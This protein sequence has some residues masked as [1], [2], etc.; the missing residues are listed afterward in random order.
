[1][2]KPLK[3]FGRDGESQKELFGKGCDVSSSSPASQKRLAT[4]NAWPLDS[5]N[6]TTIGQSSITKPKGSK[7]TMDKIIK[8]ANKANPLNWSP[9]PPRAPTPE[10]NKASK[11]VKSS[12]SKMSHAR[13]QHVVT[14]ESEDAVLASVE[15]L[16]ADTTIGVDG[17]HRGA[18]ERPMNV[19][20]LGNALQLPRV[21]QD[22]SSVSRRITQSVWDIQRSRSFTNRGRDHAKHRRAKTLL[23]SMEGGTSSRND[24]DFF[25]VAATDDHFRDFDKIYGDGNV[26]M[27]ESGE[28][29]SDNVEFSGNSDNGIESQYDDEPLCTETLPLLRRDSFGSKKISDRHLKARNVLKK[30]H[31]K[32]IRELLNPLRMLKNLGRCIL[33]STLFVSLTFFT[34]AWILYYDCGNPPSPDFLPGTSRLS[35]WCNFAGKWKSRIVFFGVLLCSWVILSLTGRQ[36]LLLELARIVQFLFIDCFLLAFRFVSHA[37]G[38]WITIFC[39]QVRQSLLAVNR[40]FIAC[41]G[42]T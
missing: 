3:D 20:S 37:L 17:F 24:F 39:I 38:P 26:T 2:T 34:T 10:S 27:D 42:L 18:Q 36:L 9:K 29:E 8:T 23:T 25:G 30:S 7:S 1:M 22:S 28:T 21:K 40:R 31:L 35:W 14:D 12:L 33:H 41:S 6:K 11:S 32:R 16:T 19:S 5:S 4:D 15:E 13:Q